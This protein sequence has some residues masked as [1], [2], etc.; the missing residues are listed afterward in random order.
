VI[1][2]VE[3][4]NGIKY[5]SLAGINSNSLRKQGIYELT[6]SDFNTKIALNL[7]RSESDIELLSQDE[8][9]TQL[10]SARIIHRH[11]DSI[12]NGIESKQLDLEKPKE[13]WRIFI[14]LALLFFVAEMA[15]IKFMR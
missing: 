5:I 11:I 6:S 10:E 12:E 7:N 3:R 1:P 2:T 9:N 15:I 14:I 13:F 4:K 8:I